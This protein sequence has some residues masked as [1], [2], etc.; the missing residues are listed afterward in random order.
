MSGS[1]E[2]DFSNKHKLKNVKIKDG[3]PYCTFLEANKIVQFL[4]LHF[5][6]S[7]KMYMYKYYTGKDNVENK[8]IANYRFYYNGIY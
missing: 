5:Q 1:Y 4:G 3:I 2:Y 6:G 8:I 7:S